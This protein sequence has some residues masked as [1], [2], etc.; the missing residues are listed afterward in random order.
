MFLAQNIYFNALTIIDL[1]KPS[2][3]KNE[4]KSIIKSAACILSQ[5][6]LHNANL[7]VASS[8]MTASLSNSPQPCSTFSV[9]ILN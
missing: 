4:L 6:I 5:S 1:M 8:T 9:Q 3:G 7:D 2:V